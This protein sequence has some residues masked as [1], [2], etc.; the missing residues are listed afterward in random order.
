MQ[1][2]QGQLKM[3]ERDRYKLAQYFKNIDFTCQDISQ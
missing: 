3:L 1:K 2:P